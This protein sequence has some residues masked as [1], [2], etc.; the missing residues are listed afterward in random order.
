MLC[1]RA[2]H[3]A[4]SDGCAS[5]AP[6]APARPGHDTAG[7]EDRIPENESRFWDLV[8]EWVLQ[9][10]ARTRLQRPGAYQ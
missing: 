9:A 6:T 7:M 5:P 2:R 8:A 10:M 1:V 4:V 3:G